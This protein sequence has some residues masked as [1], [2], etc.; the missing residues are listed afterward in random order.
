VE[1]LYAQVNTMLVKKIYGFTSMHEFV[2]RCT[3]EIKRRVRRRY[4]QLN[5]AATS[6]KAG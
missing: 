6:A 1:E 5:K 4:R 3:P 2:A